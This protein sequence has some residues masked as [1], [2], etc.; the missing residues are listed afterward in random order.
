MKKEPMLP[1]AFSYMLVEFNE[2]VQEMPPIKI[3]EEPLL[4]LRAQAETSNELNSRQK[5][6]IIVRVD[7]YLNGTYGKSK[8]FF[9]FKAS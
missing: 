1:C 6:A 5:D 9:N 3:I 4:T 8:E 7:N 2:M